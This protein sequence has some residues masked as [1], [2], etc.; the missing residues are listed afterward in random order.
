MGLSLSPGTRKQ[1][2]ALV[3]NAE[4]SGRKHSVV[5]GE[6][7]AEVEMKLCR[8]LEHVFDSICASKNTAGVIIEDLK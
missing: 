7:T 3:L 2:R 6:T 4:R 1:P 5:A 8:K